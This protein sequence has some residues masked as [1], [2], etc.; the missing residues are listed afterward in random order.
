MTLHFYDFESTQKIN[1]YVI[2][3][4]LKRELICK[5]INRIPGRPLLI[6]SL[7]GSASKMLVESLGKSC[8]STSILEA[9]HGKLYI[10]RRSPRILY[11][12]L[13]K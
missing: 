12:Y 7:P 5:L 9:L 3:A 1:N 13:P 6:S 8:N 4:S 11:I 10:R 2:V